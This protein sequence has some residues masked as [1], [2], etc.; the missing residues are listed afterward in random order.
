MSDSDLKFS[1]EN[2]A[3]Q[4]LADIT[5]KKIRIAS[6]K[7]NMNILRQEAEKYDSA[8]ELLKSGGFSIESL[9][10]VAFGFSADDIKELDPKD[11][12]IKWHDDLYNVQQ[13]IKNSKLSE[14]EWA[15]KINLSE[16]IDVVY[17]D[18]K[19]YVEDGHHRYY[20]ALVLGKKL[21]V[22]LEIKEKPIAKIIGTK[23][24]DYDE[25]HRS[26][27]ASIE[28]PTNED[29]KIFAKQISNELGLKSFFIYLNGNDL[30][31]DS[32]IVE[33]AEQKQGKGSAAM[34]S[35]TDYADKHGFRIVLTTGT[36]DSHHGTTSSTRLK[37]FY[38][39]F[40][41]IENKG[42]NKDFA[43]SGNMYRSSKK[44]ASI[45]SIYRGENASNKKGG[46]FWTQDKGWA[47]QFT[48]TGKVEEVKSKRIDS[49]DIYVVENPPYAG[50]P[51]AI[52]EIVKEA[53]KK[54]YKAVKL[55]EGRNEPQSIYVFNR[56]ALVASILA[57]EVTI[58]K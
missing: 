18:D 5:G 45:I 10:R 39:R 53:K 55:D 58:E 30:T 4:Y 20:A 40:G 9:D 43:L 21:K 54:G 27:F 7:N 24:Y 16:P 42:R 47:A 28:K 32:I 41:F 3:I 33:K 8:E 13:E 14:E 37:K 29:V 56:I 12:N 46:K 25:F 36:K 22:N 52:D 17:E 19:F 50:D 44:I 51:D 48:Q 26:F 34:Q 57:S 23:K 6:F 11:L 35:L 31:L 49:K 1:S 2:N 15:K 38:K